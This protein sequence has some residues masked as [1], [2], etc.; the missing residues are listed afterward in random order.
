MNNQD[1]YLP[2]DD[3]E[4]I[5]NVCTQFEESCR[6]STPPRIED[7]LAGF[8][9]RARQQL[10]LEDVMD[11][12]SIFLAHSVDGQTLPAEHGYPLRLVAKGEYGSYWVKWVGVIE[13]K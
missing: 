12:D 8:E 1:G 11:N 10:L 7:L 4:Q 6:T 9:G 2:N 3:L 13:V 5:D